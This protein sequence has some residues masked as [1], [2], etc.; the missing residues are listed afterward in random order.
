MHPTSRLHTLANYA[1][2]SRWFEQPEQ[3]P[4]VFEQIEREILNNP[5]FGIRPVARMNSVYK[6][7]MNLIAIRG[8]KDFQA[9]DFIEF[10]ALDD[11]HIFPQAYLKKLEDESHQ[12]R[13]KPAEINT[14]VNKTLIS[15][16][17][18]RRISRQSP[19][20]YLERL[21]PKERC[22]EILATHF[23]E[24]DALRAMENDDYDA[25]LEAREQALLNEIRRVVAGD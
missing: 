15:S 21:V 6:G 17:M 20:Q 9:D 18:N 12:P 8:A 1:E 3:K 11:H 7:I 5:N 13:Y 10:H 23:I 16:R 14:I 2:I 25:F 24:G 19:S 22:K 4:D